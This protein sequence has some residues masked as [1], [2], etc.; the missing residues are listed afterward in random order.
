MAHMW[1]R[2]GRSALQAL[3]DGTFLL[4]IEHG[5]HT[6]LSRFHLVFCFTFSSRDHVPLFSMVLA[7]LRM[8]LLTYLPFYSNLLPR[9]CVT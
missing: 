5:R 4:W 8:A 6:T 9:C 3:R 7:I 2:K 1:Q